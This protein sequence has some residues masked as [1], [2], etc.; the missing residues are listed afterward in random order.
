MFSGFMIHAWEAATIVALVAGVVGFFTVMRGAAFAAH[1]LPNGA[2]AGAAGASLIAVNALIGLGVFSLAGAITIAALGR[3]ARN[4]VAT[5]LTIILMLGLGALFL[6]QT[7]EYAPEI[8]ALLFGE[9]LGV[10]SNELIPTAAIAAGCIVAILVLYRPLLLSSAIP[11]VAQA[12]GISSRRMDLLFLLVVALTT[13]MA[14]PVVGSLLIFSLLI[15]PAAAARSLTR[16]PLPAI[17]LSVLIALGTVWAAIAISYLTNL[18][19]GFFV[20][21]ISALSYA[22]GRGGAAW[23][24]HTTRRIDRASAPG[25]PSPSSMAMR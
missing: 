21:T 6:S 20:G 17:C 18:P 22:M 13:T 1:A 11:D 3:R 15:G 8:Y 2:F 14:V 5:A 10:S 16:R 9:I 25:P 19:I 23:Q 12:R 7:S 4:D 24:H